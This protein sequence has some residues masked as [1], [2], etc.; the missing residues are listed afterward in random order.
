MTDREAMKMAL[1]A[2]EAIMFTRNVGSA[3]IIA[4]NARYSLREA[5]AQDEQKPVAYVTDNYSRD[6]VNDEISSYLPVGTNLYIAPSSKPLIA[7]TDDEIID[8]YC[9]IADGTE[10][11]IGGL[12][13][14]L[15]FARAIE[16]KLG[17]KNYD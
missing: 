13:N 6:G 3:H 2:L 9:K 1:E 17:R 15:P 16:A 11:A 14:A 12:E 4:K 8:E 7:L 10:W 5:L